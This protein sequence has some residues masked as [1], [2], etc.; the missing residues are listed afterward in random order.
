MYKEIQG[1]QHIQ[2]NIISSF[3]KNGVKNEIA[4]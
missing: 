3:G 4:L 2:C 1:L